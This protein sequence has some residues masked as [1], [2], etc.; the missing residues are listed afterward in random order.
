[1]RTKLNLPGLV[2]ILLILFLSRISPALGQEPPDGIACAADYT[3]QISDSISTIAQKQYGS[4]DAYQV[5]IDAT[6]VAAQRDN[7][8]TS[9]PDPNIIAVGQVLCLPSQEV[10]QNLLTDRLNPAP[11]VAPPPP[12]PSQNPAQS[13]IQFSHEALVTQQPFQLTLSTQ[14]NGTIHYTTNGSWPT[15]ESTPYTGPIAINQTTVIQAQV[16]DAAGNPVGEMQTNSYIIANYEQTIPVFSVVTDWSYLNTLHANPQQRSRE[17]ERPI[18]LEY[19]A[20]GGQRQFDVKAGIRIHGN[21]SRLFSPKK[22]YRFYFRQEYGGPEQIEY[23]FFEDTPVT[24]FDTL[25]LRAG[26]QDTFVHRNIP[27]RA[28]RHHTAKYISDQVARNLHRDMGQPIAH[29]RW[30]LLYLNGEFWGLYNLTEYIDLDFLRSYSEPEAEWDIIVKE[31]GWENGQWYSRE[32]MRDGGYGGWL[33][34]QN[35]MGSADFTKWESIGEWEWRVD[36]ENIFSYMFLQAYVQHTDWPGANWVVYRRWDSG[37]DGN[38]QKWRMMV[39]DTED[40]FGGGEDNRVDMNTLERVYS[41]HDSITRILE[42]AFIGSCYLKN[43]FV[44]R[45]REY[46]GIENLNNRPANEVGQLSKER[47]KAE[48]TRQAD[49]V[50]PFIALET[51]RWAPDLPGVDIFNQNIANMLHFVDVREEVILEHLRILKDQTFTQCQ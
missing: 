25:V 38:E 50:R 1:M 31:S 11:V 18:N 41:P 40:S 44:Q 37:A 27:E 2:L 8:Y 42:K 35:W 45:A 51:Q 17:W 49:L 13:A 22:S 33:E 10:A 21:F 16:F 24:K 15:P 5:I 20:P 12:V 7:K 4:V 30:V 39:W 34:N 28:D 23:P 19:F 3:V 32:E 14:H 43:D 36:K 29:G 6:N 47:V 9:I 48:I 46:L 26:F